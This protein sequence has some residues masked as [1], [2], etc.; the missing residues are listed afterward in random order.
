MEGEEREEGE[1][2]PCPDEGGDCWEDPPYSSAWCADHPGDPQCVPASCAEGW[3]GVIDWGGCWPGTTPPNQWGSS[4]TQE[5]ACDLVFPGGDIDWDRC[6]Y[7]GSGGPGWVPCGQAP[8]LCDGWDREDWG[9]APLTIDWSPPS[10]EWLGTQ[11]SL[12]CTDSHLVIQ[13]PCV[14][15]ADDLTCCARDGVTRCCARWH[16][17]TWRITSWCELSWP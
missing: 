11:A 17:S 6:R 13:E 15:T 2:G 9:D 12:A 10:A 8:S 14:D 16:K 4:W 3:D 5:F 1:E 7:T